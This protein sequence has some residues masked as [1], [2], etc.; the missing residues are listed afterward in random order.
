MVA[1]ALII[2]AA[3]A[4]LVGGAIG[5]AGGST[6]ASPRV[7]VTATVTAT[8]T[9]AFPAPA[10]SPAPTSAAA[11]GRLADQGWTVIQV[12]LHES[13]GDFGGTLRV[14]N[15]TGVTVDAPAFTVSLLKGGSQVASMLGGDLATVPPGKI[16]TVNLISADT[17]V[18]GPYGYEFQFSG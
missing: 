11:S 6:T 10:N 8:A 5:S 17:W 7:T 16:I 9:V 2:V 18:A 3:V 4:L 14:R 13:H 15:D 1:L 12:R